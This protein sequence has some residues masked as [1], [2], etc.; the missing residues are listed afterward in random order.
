MFC[1]PTRAHLASIALPLQIYN[2]T[3]AAI[4]LSK[5]AFPSVGNDPR[6]PGEHEYWNRLGENCLASKACRNKSIQSKGTYVICHPQATGQITAK[7]DQTHKYLSNG[8][9]GYC[10]VKGTETKYEF[11]DC[12]SPCAL[13]TA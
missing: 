4:D 1:C 11:V 12:T 5:Y 10:L 6:N 8:D 3:D 13:A 2:P 9:D 7:C